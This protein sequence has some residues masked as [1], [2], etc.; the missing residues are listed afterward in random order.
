MGLQFDSVPEKISPFIRAVS[1]VIGVLGFAA[2]AFNALQDGGLSLN[3]ISA[4]SFLAGY[5][6]LYVSFFG[7]YPWDRKGADDTDQ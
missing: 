2:I 6:F 4:A 1:G 3:L 5:V 7:K